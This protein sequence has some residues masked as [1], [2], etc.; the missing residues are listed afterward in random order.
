VRTLL[1]GPARAEALQ[2]VYGLQHCM[3]ELSLQ[4]RAFACGAFLFRML[5]VTAHVVDVPTDMLGVTRC[6]HIMPYMS[7]S[8]DMIDVHVFW[9]PVQSCTSNM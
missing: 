7:M 5:C 1:A 8:A 2:Q 4:H 9:V 3:A 6:H